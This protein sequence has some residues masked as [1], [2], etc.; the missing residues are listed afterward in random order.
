MGQVCLQ[1][2]VEGKG[3]GS[4]LGPVKLDFTVGLDKGS[5]TEAYKPVYKS[6]LLAKINSAA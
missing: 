3:E 5:G 4:G 2:V 6:L 1:G